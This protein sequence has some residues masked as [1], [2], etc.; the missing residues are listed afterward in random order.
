MV[1]PQKVKAAGQA[2]LADVNKA[3]GWI[4]AHPRFAALITFFIGFA[5]G[6]L[7]T[8]VHLHK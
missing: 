8:C 5:F 7:A 4:D 3:E 6:A 1:D 2:A